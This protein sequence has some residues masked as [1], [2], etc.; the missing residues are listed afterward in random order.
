A[1]GRARCAVLAPLRPPC[2]APDSGGPER[3]GD[4]CRD[5]LGISG[6][7]GRHALQGGEGPRQPWITRRWSINELR[8]RLGGVASSP[9]VTSRIAL[10][11]GSSA[12]SRQ[13]HCSQNGSAP[14]EDAH[15]VGGK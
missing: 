14:T 6:P 5:V 4:L 12:A 9:R 1:A 2:T 15:W 3:C 8:C 13:Y 10:G 7:R 11:R